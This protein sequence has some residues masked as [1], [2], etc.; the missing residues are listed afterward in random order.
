MGFYKPISWK[1][2]ANALYINYSLKYRKLLRGWY[3]SV[4]EKNLRDIY[5]WSTDQ[6]IDIKL[7]DLD[8]HKNLLSALSKVFEE[9]KH[10]VKNVK[11]P[12]LSQYHE[13]FKEFSSDFV[14]STYFWSPMAGGKIRGIGAFK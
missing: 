2:I 13:F 7:S 1:V 6:N 4:Y 11:H 10:I 14:M 12:L 9:M 3:Q 5:G 8:S